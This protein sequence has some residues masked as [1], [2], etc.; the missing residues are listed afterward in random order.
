MIEQLLQ[1]V[2]SLSATVDSLN[3]AIEA[4]TQFIAQRNQTI[5]ELKEQFSRNFQNSSKPPSSDDFKSL[6]P[7]V[8][9]NHPI[10]KPAGRTYTGEFIRL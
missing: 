10:K 2:K 5:Q 6:Y 1:Q 9:V 8:C 3:T 7:K 4:Q